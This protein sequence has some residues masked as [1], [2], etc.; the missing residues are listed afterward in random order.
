VERGGDGVMGD[1]WGLASGGMREE[2]G[3]IG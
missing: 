3:E 2:V 1:W